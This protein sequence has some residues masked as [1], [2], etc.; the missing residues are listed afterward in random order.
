MSEKISLQELE[1]HFR[2]CVVHS[3]GLP[4]TRDFIKGFQIGF[5]MY[6]RMANALGKAVTEN[7][8]KSIEAIQSSQ[9]V[10]GSSTD[11]D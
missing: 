8:S 2:L 6:E 4:V 7:E 3:K 9:P 10:D 1:R 11:K 5:R